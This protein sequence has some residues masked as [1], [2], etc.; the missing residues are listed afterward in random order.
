MS[1]TAETLYHKILILLTRDLDEADPPSTHSAIELEARL[2]E[3][4]KQLIA[5]G[6]KADDVDDAVALVRDDLHRLGLD[7]EHRG[8]DLGDWLALDIDLLRDALLDILRQA[9]DPTRLGW[10]RLALELAAA[11]RANTT[12]PTD[13][14][15]DGEHDA[16][17]APVAR[18][19]KTPSGRHH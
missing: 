6:A 13:D 10:Q 9:A 11:R 7:L 14:R 4:R 17:S 3:A 15:H 12:H 19:N 5:Q 1:Q 18:P 16:S 2:A 8:L